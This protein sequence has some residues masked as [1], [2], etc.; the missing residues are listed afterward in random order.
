MFGSDVSSVATW[1]PG[2]LA[3]PARAPAARPLVIAHRGASGYRPEHTLESYRVAIA[4]GADYVEPDLVVTAD[5]VLV[6][7]HEN[8][9]GAT[10]D[11]ATHP[12]F[13]DRRT[14]K[15]VAGREVTGWFVED[16]SLAE[17]KMLRARE[18]LPHLRAHNRTYDGR[19]DV[20]TFDEIVDLVLAESRRRGRLIGV[21]PE[22]KQPSHFAA[23]G[24]Q[25][26]GPLL[27]TLRRAGPHLPAYIQ[28]FDPATLRAMAARTT[29][30]LV[31]LV[32]HDDDLLTPRGLREVSTYAQVLGPRKDLVG[33]RDGSGGP[34]G[35]VD[36]AHEAGLSVHVWTFRNENAFL[37]PVDRRGSEVA[38]F[39][40]ALGEYAKFLSLGVEG[41]FTDHPDT[42]RSA[43]AAQPS[44]RCHQSRESDGD[45]QNRCRHFEAGQS[46]DVEVHERP[47]QA[48]SYEEK[49]EHQRDDVDVM[50]LH[51]APRC[52]RCRR[53]GRA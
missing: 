32:R 5:G 30:P 43:V 13:A 36:R 38:A 39:G 6:A 53:R 46:E 1:S 25:H 21:Y 12:R 50:A 8:E 15:A 33:T 7:R 40:D 4:L 42:A 22:I 23:L 19:F 44:Q 37:A 49:T 31:Q 41:V 27:A 45:E 18:R 52:F 35:L 28:S 14:T 51:G 34:I 24:L 48:H 11:V 16:F 9:I 10:T 29:V 2:L 20:P 26:E 3:P 17:L 47:H